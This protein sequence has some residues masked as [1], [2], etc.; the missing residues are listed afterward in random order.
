MSWKITFTR[1]KDSLKFTTWKEGSNK[2]EAFTNACKDS[3]V[4][5]FLAGEGL[6]S[7]SI[8]QSDYMVNSALRNLN[9]NEEQKN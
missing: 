6:Y 1:L 5:A 4:A 8:I 3:A 7:K 2:E 9:I